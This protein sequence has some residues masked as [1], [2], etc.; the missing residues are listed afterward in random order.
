MNGN[1]LRDAALGLATGARPIGNGEDLKCL[2]RALVLLGLEEG[3]RTV[4]ELPRV[5]PVSKAL[6]FA[7]WRDLVREGLVAETDHAPHTRLVL[8]PHGHYTLRVAKG[9]LRRTA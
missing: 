2:A 8:T 5:W 9:E 3:S 7:A 1:P 6:L 4:P